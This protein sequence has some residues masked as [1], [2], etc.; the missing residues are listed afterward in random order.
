MSLTRQ[1]AQHVRDFH[2]GGNYAGVHLKEAV[3]SITWK[4]ATTSVHSFNTIA[5][6]VFHINY[7]ISVVLKVLQGQPFEAHDKYSYQVPPIENEADWQALLERVWSEAALFAQLIEQ[8]PDS[9]LS[10]HFL[11][12][13]Y[14][15]Y[16]RNL[17]GAIEHGH[18][19]LGQITLI[20][21][22]LKRQ[23]TAI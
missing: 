17:E 11:D 5:A 6:L 23:E 3:S 9:Q 4:E 22:L 8:L 20:K 10:S 14:G 2:F 21:K 7:Y 15:S 12:G 13:K 18:Y 19:H 16:F 1:L